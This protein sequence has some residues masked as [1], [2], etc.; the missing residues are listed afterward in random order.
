MPYVLDTSWNID[1]RI[2]MSCV[3]DAV[4]SI[5]CRWDAENDSPMCDAKVMRGM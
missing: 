1:Y 2:I 3:D 4:V 5:A